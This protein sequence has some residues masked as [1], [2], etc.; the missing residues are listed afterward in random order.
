MHS[1]AGFYGEVP[2]LES[3][4]TVAWREQLQELQSYMEVRSNSIAYLLVDM[5]VSHIPNIGHKRLLPPPVEHAGAPRV[6]CA[7][8][9]LR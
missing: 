8:A 9:R 3:D 6:V 1:L 7:N 2:G 4:K 5:P